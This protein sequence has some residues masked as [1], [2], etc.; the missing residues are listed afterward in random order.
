MGE[1]EKIDYDTYR[2]ME[3]RLKILVGAR[4][5][6][7]GRAMTAA[8]KQDELRGRFGMPIEG[9]NSTEELRKWRGSL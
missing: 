5:K 6:D 9:W 8:K 3:K 7:K 2:S 1:A 4:W